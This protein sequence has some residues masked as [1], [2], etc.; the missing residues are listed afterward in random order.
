MSA[1]L[2]TLLAWHV[3]YHHTVTSS[4]SY[5]HSHCTIVTPSHIHTI[6]VIPTYSHTISQYIIVHEPSQSHHHTSHY[7]SHT[8]TV[9]PSQVTLL[10]SHTIAVTPSQ[11]HHHIQ[12]AGH[13]HTVI[14]PPLSEFCARPP[15]MGTS[16]SSAN[17]SNNH[18]YTHWHCKDVV[19]AESVEVMCL[20]F[21][22]CYS[23]LEW[24]WHRLGVPGVEVG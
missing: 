2:Y 19:D 9:T 12:A 24:R 4:Q 22:N 1:E 6:L 14:V 15:L 20:E 16:Y 13:H 10:H 23:T 21:E 17:S 11:L 18:I 7:H 5:H 8:I 3:L